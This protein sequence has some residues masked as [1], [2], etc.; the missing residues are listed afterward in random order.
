[1]CTVEHEK[2][3]TGLS[4][5]SI[6]LQPILQHYIHVFESSTT[7][8]PLREIDYKITLVPNCEPIN[9][10]SYKY[11]YFQ[12]IKFKKTATELLISE[13][14]RPSTNPFASPALLV[15]KKDDS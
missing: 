2:P 4:F 10:R 11:S 7:L 8:P 12:K 3:H 6:E 13:V 15:K 1:M 9:L 14:I 5:I